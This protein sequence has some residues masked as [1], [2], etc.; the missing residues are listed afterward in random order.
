MLS[1]QLVVEPPYV[2]KSAEQKAVLASGR[3]THVAYEDLM[4]NGLTVMDEYQIQHG[5]NDAIEL[6]PEGSSPDVSV[7]FGPQ[8]VKL[9]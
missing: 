2:D 8:E 1:K 5:G 6:N 9:P 4:Q 3:S 7:E